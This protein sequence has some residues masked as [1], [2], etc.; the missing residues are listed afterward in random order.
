MAAG[1]DVDLVV[2]FDVNLV[3]LSLAVTFLIGA[4][5]TLGAGLAATLVAGL[6]IA[7]VFFNDIF[8]FVLGTGSALPLTCF[9]TAL[10]LDLA[11][12]LAFFTVANVISPKASV[13]I[14][15]GFEPNALVSR[16]MKN[17]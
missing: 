7:F 17:A 13:R 3:V 15:L 6:A 9:A 12:G 8:A 5:V 11:T 1:L 4:L 10:A 14:Q 2:A 16:I